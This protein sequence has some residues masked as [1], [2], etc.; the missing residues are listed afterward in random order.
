MRLTHANKKVF[1][2]RHGQGFVPLPILVVLLLLA[3][4]GA[5]FAGFFTG[6]GVQGF[7]AIFAVI[8]VVFAGLS[9][10]PAL[11]RW[12]HAVRKEAKKK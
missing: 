10:L 1:Q 2:L 6:R 11:I 5:G 4:G 12:F 8:L 7:F 9:Y 3:F